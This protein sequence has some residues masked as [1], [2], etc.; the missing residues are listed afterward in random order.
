MYSKSIE[1]ERTAKSPDP[2]Y[3]YNR[4]S[5]NRLF[6]QTG[7][8]FIL[9]RIAIWEFNKS[10]IDY[11]SHLQST[12]KQADVKYMRIMKLKAIKEARNDK[13]IESIK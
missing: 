7:K 9:T 12:E 1:D 13:S 2:D 10:Q 11:K 5:P 8:W 3:F 4:Q 6:D